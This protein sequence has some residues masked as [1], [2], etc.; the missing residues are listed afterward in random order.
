[1][2][3][4]IA[5]RP[6]IYLKFHTLTMMVTKV[7]PA[8]FCSNPYSQ[9]ISWKIPFCWSGVALACG[10]IS[11]EQMKTLW[12]E[13]DCWYLKHCTGRISY[14]ESPSST[15]MPIVPEVELADGSFSAGDPTTWLPLSPGRQPRPYQLP[16][17]NFVYPAPGYLRLVYR[18]H[19]K[20]GIEDNFLDTTMLMD[21]HTSLREYLDANPLLREWV[22]DPK[23]HAD[24]VSDRYG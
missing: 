9:S 13:S 10:E 11:H 24:R 4:S 6:I 16:D 12:D 20:A 18:A 7:I 21:R 17:R 1:M 22:T 3:S 19:C 2:G 5:K 23:R 8:V 14:I 15:P